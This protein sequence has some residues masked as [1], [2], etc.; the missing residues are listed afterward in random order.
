MQSKLKAL[1]ANYTW[2]LADLSKDKNVVG[3]NWVYRIKRKANGSIERYMAGLVAKGFTQLEGLDFYETSAP[4]VKMNTVRIFLA[5]AVAKN[6]PL[7]QLDVDNAFLHGARRNLYG[8]T[9][10]LL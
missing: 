10:W 1:A 9:S 2:E 8:A 7:F 6:W 4:V 5:I 3:S